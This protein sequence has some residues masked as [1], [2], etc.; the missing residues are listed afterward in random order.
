[1]EEK[2]NRPK[3]KIG[4]IGNIGIPTTKKRTLASLIEEFESLEKEDIKP[5]YDLSS[6]FPTK[7]IQNIALDEVDRINKI[8]LCEKL[9]IS[10]TYI[11]D[12]SW[13]EIIRE[14]EKESYKNK[15]RKRK[16]FIKKRGV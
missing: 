15:N 11:N 10:Y 9:S 3:G 7:E 1:M 6:V 13:E 12:V 8:Q 5:T 4:I 2:N 16:I 14:I